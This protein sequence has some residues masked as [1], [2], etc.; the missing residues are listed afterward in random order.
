MLL[1]LYFLSECR[2]VRGKRKARRRT[3]VPCSTTAM[4]AVKEANAVG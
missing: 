2:F 3:I 4:V 1:R